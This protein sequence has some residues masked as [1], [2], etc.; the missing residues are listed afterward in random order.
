[1]GGPAQATMEMLQE[2]LKPEKGTPSPQY[3][4]PMD[5][6]PLHQIEIGSN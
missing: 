4:E 6:P 2:C 1:M 3:Q 5:P